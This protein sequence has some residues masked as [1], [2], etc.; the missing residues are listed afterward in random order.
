[1]GVDFILGLLANKVTTNNYWNIYLLEGD[2]TNNEM[3]FII[4]LLHYRE[5]RIDCK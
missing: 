2:I 1:M 3:T 4:T 5:L